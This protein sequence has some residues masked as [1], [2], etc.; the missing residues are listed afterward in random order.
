MPT[1]NQ[2]NYYQPH[3]FDQPIR[4][5]FWRKK[6]EEIVLLN[7][8]ETQE[9]KKLVI[10]TEFCRDNIEKHSENYHP[11]NCV[12]SHRKSLKS[13]CWTRVYTEPSYRCKRVKKITGVAMKIRNHS[14]I[15]RGEKIR[16]P[17]NTSEQDNR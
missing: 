6:Q 14:K 3:L 1:P 4:H 5:C 16:E 13:G 11:I 9:I 15:R 12:D 10:H 2:A 7:G 17:V 8:K